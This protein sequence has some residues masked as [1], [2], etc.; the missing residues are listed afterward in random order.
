MLWKILAVLHLIFWLIAAFEILSSARPLANK[1]LWLL[2]IFLLPVVGLVLYY[3]L[4]RK[5]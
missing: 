3:L 4:G 5:N 1:V 2:V